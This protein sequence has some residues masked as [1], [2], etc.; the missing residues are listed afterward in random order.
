M[1]TLGAVS[2]SIPCFS[3][4]DLSNLAISS[5]SST[6]RMRMRVR[7]PLG[8]AEAPHLTPAPEDLDGKFHQA[9]FR[10]CWFD[11]LTPLTAAGSDM[12]RYL[13]DSIGVLSM[14][15]AIAASNP[16]AAQT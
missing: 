8:R 5:S 10:Q 15:V 6:S 14:A 16:C 11:R 7:V 9:M 13:F 12:R 2:S 4:A 1:A 3:N